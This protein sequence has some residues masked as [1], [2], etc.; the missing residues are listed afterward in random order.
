M[1]NI[2][3]KDCLN[4][5]YSDCI[6]DE[7]EL[8]DFIDSESLDKEIIDNRKVFDLSS[9]S[10]YENSEKGKKARCKAAKKYYKMNKTKLLKNSKDYYSQHREEIKAK[11]RQRY[12]EQKR[13]CC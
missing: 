13:R 6:C 5:K 12:E 8:I 9:K 10:K 2:C 11:R 4:C 1:G 3:D 7:Y